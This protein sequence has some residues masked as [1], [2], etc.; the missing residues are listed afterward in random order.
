MDTGTD[1]G[2]LSGVNANLTAVGFRPERPYK[3]CVAGD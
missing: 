3:L 2:E 1:V